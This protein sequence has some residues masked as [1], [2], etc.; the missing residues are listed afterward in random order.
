[1]DQSLLEN[2]PKINGSHAT[3]GI[4]MTEREK[5]GYSEKQARKIKKLGYSGKV[6]QITEG[7]KSSCS[8][9]NQSA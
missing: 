1:M 2:M 9:I 8:L 6:E 7:N 5:L 3:V 4:L